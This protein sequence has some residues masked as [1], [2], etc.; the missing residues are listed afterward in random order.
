[1]KEAYQK[2]TTKLWGWLDGFI[3]M[4]P[5]LIVAILVL[6]ATIFISKGLKKIFLK[7]IGRFSENVA[8]SRLLSNIFTI[9]IFTIGFFVALSIL[10]LDKAVTSLLAGAGVVGL[11]IGLAFQEPILNVFSGI[12]M[13]VQEPFKIGDIIKTNDYF[14]TI[15]TISLRSTGLKKFSG[16]DVI[17]PNKLVIQNPIENYTMTQFRRVAIK[18]GVS[19]SDNLEL[20]EKIAIE[21]IEKEIPHDKSKPVEVYFEEFGASSINFELRF[22]LDMAEQKDFL[23]YKS[24]AIKAVKKYFDQN[25]IS[26]PFPIRTLE[27]DKGTIESMTKGFGK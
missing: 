26:I 20:V 8:V 5:N 24:D 19:Y 7:V 21:A 4:I 14:G 6:V 17:I 25:K 22:W 16:E 13:S 23:K 11:A 12:V 27:I 3:L 1:M 10:E 2:L 18:C 9:V 15:T